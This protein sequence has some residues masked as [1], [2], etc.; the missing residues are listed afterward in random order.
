[1]KRWFRPRMEDGDGLSSLVLL[2]FTS[3]VLRLKFNFDQLIKLNIIPFLL[4]FE[5]LTA[6][7]FTY[8]LGIFIVEFMWYFDEGSERTSW[9]ASI[10]VGVTLGSGKLGQ[11]QMTSFLL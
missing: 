7:G 11:M 3:L 10:M 4:F 1:M 8:T 6:D 5:I 9:I 2:W